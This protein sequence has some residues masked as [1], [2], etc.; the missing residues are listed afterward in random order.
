MAEPPSQPSDEF[1]DRDGVLPEKGPAPRAVLDLR[2]LGLERCAVDAVFRA[3]DVIVL[4][5][6]SRPLIR[7]S[8]YL[9][10]LE[11]CTCDEE[12]VC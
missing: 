5:S 8:D 4:L 10:L 12:K 7:V 3:L 11:R 6:H 1:R 2:K 9:E